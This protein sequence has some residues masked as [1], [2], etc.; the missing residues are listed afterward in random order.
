MVEREI[1]VVA[2]G[3]NIEH[4]RRVVQRRPGWLLRCLRGGAAPP[5]H[6]GDLYWPIDLTVAAAMVTLPLRTPRRVTVPIAHDAVTGH[7]GILDLSI[8]ELKTTYASEEEIVRAGAGEPAA[9][10]QEFAREQFVRRHRPTKIRDLGFEVVER[11]HLPYHVLTAG[12]SIFLVDRLTGRVD[13]P[14]RHPYARMLSR[15]RLDAIANQNP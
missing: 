15:R 13:H 10:L 4:S 6:H 5:H 8:P 1:R 7:H 9:E 14:E 12:T 2:V 3:T 11:V